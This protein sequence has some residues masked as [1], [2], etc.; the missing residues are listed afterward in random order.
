MGR[1]DKERQHDGRVML[2]YV[3]LSEVRGWEGL[4]RCRNSMGG[5]HRGEARLEGTVRSSF[6]ISS[7]K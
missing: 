6:F 1:C 4:E 3:G 5:G 7:V 2:R